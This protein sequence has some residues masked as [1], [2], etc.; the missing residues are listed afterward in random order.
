M[1]AETP[2]ARRRDSFVFRILVA[3]AAGAFLGQLAHWAAGSPPTLAERMAGRLPGEIGRPVLETWQKLGSFASALGY[4]GGLLVSLIKGLAGPL[5]FFAVIDAFLR[6]R[7]RAR[8]A[9]MMLGI[10][11][12]NAAVAVV[13]GLTISN[14][15]Q[16]GRY[17]QHTPELD[18]GRE[19]GASSAPE[20]ERFASGTRPLDFLRDLLGFVPTN[21]VQPFLESSILSIVLLAVLGGAALRRVKDEQIRAGRDDYRGVESAVAVLYRTIEVALSWVIALVPLA[22]FGVVAKTVAEQGF[23][24]FKGLFAYVA[25]AVLGLSLQVAIMYQ[26]WVVFVARMTLRRFWGGAKEAVVYALG[27]SSS[28][29]TL[30]VTLRCLDRMGVSP[31]AARLSACVGTNFN[32]DGILLYEAMAV[33]FVAQAYGLDLTV[34]QQ[35]IAALSCVVAGIGIAGVPEAGLIS[36]ALVLSTVGLPLELLPLLLTV[37]WVLSRCRAMTN[38]VADI[39]V[40]VLLDRIGVESEPPE[41]LDDST[42]PPEAMAEAGKTNEGCPPGTGRTP[43]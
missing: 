33:L 32:N 18:A 10:S 20:L 22:V 36:L 7:V 29:A 38:V 28:L 16:P 31:T 3:M 14:A 9:A 24:P 11:G 40:A 30:P 26:A 1:D 42:A 8:N 6:S 39:L 17:L 21:P 4:L 5:L 27:A 19:A 37:D 2:T 34:G 41:A 23:E 13:I 15:I 43:S 12:I 25:V 35:V